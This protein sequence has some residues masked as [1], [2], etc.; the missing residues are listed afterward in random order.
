[1]RGLGVLIA[2]AIVVGGCGGGGGGGGESGGGPDTGAKCRQSILVSVS[3]VNGWPGVDPEAYAAELADS[4]LSLVEI[5]ALPWF[6]R[7]GP[8]DSRNPRLCTEPF[9]NE[10]RAFFA[11][12]AG[13]GISV[14][15]TAHNANAYGPR[16]MSRAAWDEHIRRIAADA[17]A[18]GADV[19]LSPISE[20]WAWQSN[21]PRL[22]ALAARSIWTGKFILP[23]AGAARRTGRPFWGGMPYDLLEVHPCSIQATRDT[24]NPGTLTV[25][26]CSPVLN[27]GPA[28]ALELGGIA[29]DVGAPL[30]FYDHFATQPDLATIRAL[31]GL[32]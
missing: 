7:S 9:L 29:A 5:E 31:K 24:I 6:D 15:V 10:R 21:E 2:A 26:D 32:Q 27:P 13:R 11:A 1:V 3:V 4:C 8:C 12:M 23:D 22:R 28:L 14:F 20:P 30:I 25:T 17:A 16:L 19:W 18:T